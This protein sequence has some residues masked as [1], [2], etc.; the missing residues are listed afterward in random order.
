MAGND[1]RSTAVA[2][3]EDF[4][5]ILTGLFIERFEAPIIQYQEEARSRIAAI[6]GCGLEIERH[7]YS[8]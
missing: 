5:Q 7:Y 1:R 6:A 2:I 8:V 3:F 4:Q